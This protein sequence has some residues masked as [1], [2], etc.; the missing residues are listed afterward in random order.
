MKIEKNQ[1]LKK[2]WKIF[3]NCRRGIYSLWL[4]II[5][6][7]FSVT[8]EFWANDRP[9]VLIYKE[10]VYFP[11]IKYYPPSALDLN[12]EAVTV[13]YKKLQLT[14]KDFALWPLIPWDPYES[15]AHV[16]E[17]PSPPTR[18]NLMGTDNR[19][20]DVLSRVLYGFRYSMGFAVL[21][22]LCSF[23]IGSLLGMVMG[24]KAGW[25]DLLGQ[26]CVEIFQSLPLNLILITF[27][28]ILGSDLWVLI[29]YSTIFGW[30]NIS[31]YIRSEYLKIRNMDYIE[32]A[33]SY[34]LRPLSIMLKHIFPNALTPLVTFSPFKIANGISLLVVLDYLGF[35]LAP[36]TPSWGELLNQAESYFTTAWWL[37]FFPS[38]FLFL[39][40]VGLNFIG[41]GIRMAFD[42]KTVMK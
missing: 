38:L 19:G 12:Q 1:L 10:Q 28:A 30:M 21:V 27:V 4:L 33:K 5:F 34:G 31:L 13:D 29:L 3:K 11:A 42:P 2:R 9:I 22:W 41:E 39:N 20:R 24:F 8:A 16:S 25:V 17:Y 18:T 23:F 40:L 7:F 36:P 32:S 6:S 37:V 26:R 14:E 15:N 35:G